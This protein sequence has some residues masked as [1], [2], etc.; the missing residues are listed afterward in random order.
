MVAA[1]CDVVMAPLAGMRRAVVADAGGA[2]LEIG[3]GTGL[4]LGL[5]DAARVESVVGVEPDPHMLRRARARADEAAVPVELTGDGA[6]ALPFADGQFDTVVA[7]WVFCTI[8]DPEAALAEIG[9]VL[10]PGGRLLF[11][12]HTLATAPPMAAMQRALDP[13]WCRLAGGCHLTRDTLGSFRGSGLG[14]LT[15][16]SSRGAAWSPTPMHRGWIVRT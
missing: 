1:L 2:V 9:R 15:V 16:A 13:V 6:E 3:V 14:E 5:Y 7:T 4:N 8:P 11:A 10:K 12:E